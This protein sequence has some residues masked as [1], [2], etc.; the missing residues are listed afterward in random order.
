[1]QPVVDQL[2]GITGFGRHGMTPFS[3]HIG[4]GPVFDQRHKFVQTVLA[5]D[6][7]VPFFVL[8]RFLKTA[9]ALRDFLRDEKTVDVA[10]ADGDVDM[11]HDAHAARDRR[12]CF[13]IIG[14]HVEF[15]HRFVSRD[16]HGDGM[17][18]R[19]A[20]SACRWR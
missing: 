7:D 18:L 3:L 12:G 1:M 16:A 17:V 2:F 20:A 6:G 5:I 9:A 15:E 4:F 14:W 10:I 11:L 19:N 8:Q 13:R